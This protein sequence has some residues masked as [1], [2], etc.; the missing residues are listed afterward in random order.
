[1]TNLELCD[2]FIMSDNDCKLHLAHLLCRNL[3]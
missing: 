2:I 1:V 3:L